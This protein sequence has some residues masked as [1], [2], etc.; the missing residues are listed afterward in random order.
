MPLFS[1]VILFR[2]MSMVS[3]SAGT[4][5]KQLVGLVHLVPLNDRLRSLSVFQS[6]VYW[7]KTLRRRRLRCS[8][9]LHRY[10]FEKSV[11]VLPDSLMSYEPPDAERTQNW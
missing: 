2:L 6:R 7:S 3:F 1:V 8:G 5:Q 4:P 10:R 9:T 11:L